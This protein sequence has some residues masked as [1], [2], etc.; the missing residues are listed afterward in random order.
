MQIARPNIECCHRTKL[1]QI[2]P[3]FTD[4]N[5][6]SR[7]SKHE[8]LENWS[9][10]SIECQFSI[11][12]VIR[13]VTRI[14]NRFQKNF[15]VDRRTMG[16]CFLIYFVISFSSKYFLCEITDYVYQC[17][18]YC[19]FN[20]LCVQF[21]KCCVFNK[22]L[23][24]HLL[25]ARIQQYDHKSACKN[26]EDAFHNLLRDNHIMVTE[27]VLEKIFQERI[28]NKM[29]T[30]QLHSLK[31]RVE[32]PTDGQKE[33]QTTLKNLR[34]KYQTLKQENEKL[35]QSLKSCS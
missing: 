19:V 13:K 4:N 34:E 30:N 11:K 27:S 25:A 15:G 23:I 24:F 35:E 20:T 8:T 14:S 2:A 6:R 33:M 3:N 5:K 32:K 16:Q 28:Q 1:N 21:M 29:K 9:K 18:N 7:E 31:E 12:P 26:C 22:L 10:S 17:M